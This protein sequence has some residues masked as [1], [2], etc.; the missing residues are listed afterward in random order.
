MALDPLLYLNHDDSSKDTN[1]T[2]V[3]NQSTK[4]IS[5]KNFVDSNVDP[6][7]GVDDVTHN[8]NGL[9]LPVSSLIDFLF[10]LSKILQNADSEDIIYFN[11]LNSTNLC[12]NFINNQFPSTIFI[13][14]LFI[15][16][17]TSK[18]TFLLLNT[19]IPLNQVLSTIVII[20]EKGLLYNRNF[21]DSQLQVINLPN[22]P[23]INS[24]NRLTTKFNDSSNIK[25]ITENS[26]IDDSNNTDSFIDNDNTDENPNSVNSSSNLII[27][28]DDRKSYETLRTL[29]N[30]GI[31]PYFEAL[32]QISNTPILDTDSQSL[33]ASISNNL[34]TKVSP[35]S[36]LI[37]INQL[38]TNNNNDDDNTGAIGSARKKLS[39]L[40]LSLQHIQ[41][42]V[43]IPDLSLTLH[44]TIKNAI[45]S[46]NH[47]NDKLPIDFIP[48]DLLSDSNFL[49]TLQSIANGWIK[50][51]QN[52]TKLSRD[53][54]EGSAADEINFWTSMES[55]LLNIQDQLNSPPIALTLEILTK[56]KRFYATL[57][58]TN[59]TGLKESLSTANKYNQLMKDLPLDELLSATTLKKIEEAIIL[60]MNHLKKLRVTNY[61]INRVLPFVEAISADLDSKLK[62]IIRTFNLMYLNF[63]EFLSKTQEINSVFLIWDKQ[64]KE[65]TNLARELLRKRSEKFIFIRINSKTRAL[66]ERL[67]YILTFRSRHNELIITLNNIINTTNKNFSNFKFNNNMN[68]INE[69]EFAFDAVRNID[70]ANTSAEGKKFWDSAEKIYNNRAQKVENAIVSMLR[71]ILSNSKSAN[72]MFSI[73]NKFNFLL[74]RP[75]VNDSIQEYQTQLLEIVKLDINN[76]QKHF[77]KQ[78]ESRRLFKAR[79]LPPV[80]SAIIWAKQIENKLNF[81]LNRLELILGKNWI[82]YVEGRK[83]Y[84][85]SVVFKKKLNTEPIYETWLNEVMENNINSCLELNIFKIVRNSNEKTDLSLVNGGLELVVNFDFN[86]IIIFK[87][88]RNLCWLNFQ[89]PHSIITS[90][91]LI[92]KVY[93]F[94]ISINESLSIFFESLIEYDTLN[95]ASILMKPIKNNLF[96]LLLDCFNIRWVDLSKAYDLQKLSSVLD[97]NRDSITGNDDLKTNITSSIDLI[98]NQYLK[99]VLSFQNSANTFH[100][101][102]ELL[103][104]FKFNLNVCFNE[105]LGCYYNKSSF[106]K[107]LS[108]IQKLVNEII[109][110]DY[111]NVSLLVKK[112]NKKIE[113]IFVSR[114]IKVTNIWIELLSN[115]Y[116]ENDFELS[117]TIKNFEIEE[118]IVSKIND[119]ETFEKKI[120][121]VKKFLPISRHEIILKDDTI[122][123]Y[124][125]IENSKLTWIWNLQQ[126]INIVCSQ[127]I[128]DESSYEIKVG[129]ENILN[130][131]ST[132]HSNELSLK[133]SNSRTNGHKSH[134]YG[135]F[136]KIN[137]SKAV[138]N[139]I[140]RCL[141]KIEE[142]FTK[143][144]EYVNSW[145]QF[146]SLYDLQLED[147]YKTLASDILSWLNVLNE[148]RQS[149]K[150]FDTIET[151]KKFGNY[152]VID[153]EQV[154]LR[155]NAKYDIWQKQIIFK[156][157]EILNLKM[158]QING[159]I[160]NAKNDLETK[161]NDL[162]STKNTVHLISNAY[163]YKSCYSLWQKN[164]S[165][166]SD[167]QA[168]LTRYRFRFPSD[169]L[170][171]EQMEG[172]FL[173]LT[174][175]L[176]MRMITIDSQIDAISKRIESESSRVNEIISSFKLNWSE[177]K[178][179]SGSIVPDDALRILKNFEKQ[180]IELQGRTDLLLKASAILSLSIAE[181][182]TLKNLF[183]EIQDL[184]NVWSS[185]DVLWKSLE[186]L[187][188][189]Q[190]HT[191]NPTKLN[192][193]LQQLLFRARTMPTRI[194]QYAAFED[195]QNV[196]KNYVQTNPLIT[197][198]KSEA[199]KHRHWLKLFS[200]L[201]IDSLSPTALRLGDIYSLQL[202]LHQHM[203]KEIVAQANGEKIIEDSLAKIKENWSSTTFNLFNYKNKC[204]L[205]K[206]WNILYEQ[207]GDDIASLVAMHHSTFF[208]IFEKEVINWE[209]KLNQLLSLFNVWIEVQRLWMYLEGIFGDNKL[210]IISLL[211]IESSRFNNIT[212]EFFLTMKRI[213]K[214]QMV[215]D[216][217]NNDNLQENM[218]RYFD[219]LSKVKKSLNDYLEKQR[220]LFP[221]FYFVGNEDL[222]E[223][224]G[225]SSDV[226]HVGKHLKKMFSGINS[227]LYEE[228]FIKGISSLEG[229]EVIL[230]NPVTKSSFL[231]EWLSELDIEIKVTL[232]ALLGSSLIDFTEIN[233]FEI[234]P[235][236]FFNWVKKY[237]AQVCLLT[238]QV[239]WTRI[240]ESSILAS[241]SN[242]EE[243]LKFLITKYERLLK[244]LAT[245]VIE[246]LDNI[247]IKKLEILIIELVHQRDVIIEMLKRKVSF[248]GDFYWKFQQTFYYDD[249]LEDY[250][251]RLKV[252][253]ANVVFS[254]GF[255]YL[256]IPDRLVYTPLTNQCFISMTQA[257]AQRL[258][259]SPF[260]PAGTGKTETI[261]SLGQNLGK[262]VLVFCCDEYFDFQAISRILFGVCRVGVWCCFDEFNRLQSSILSA[263]SSQIEKIETGLSSQKAIELSGKSAVVNL[264]TGIFITMNPTYAGRSSLPEN[265]KKQFRSFSMDKPDREIITEVI[266]IS[267]GFTTSKQISKI[268]A[269]FF[270]DL[271]KVAQKELHYDFG[272]RSIKSILSNCGKIKRKGFTL[273]EEKIAFKSIKSSIAPKLVSA[274]VEKFNE[275]TIKYFPKFVKDD[276]SDEYE[277]IIEALKLVTKEN[278]YSY[279]EEWIRKALQL[280]DI[281]SNHHGFILVGK[282]G[283]GKTVLWECL[284]KAL[285]KIDTIDNL[286]HVID[287]KVMSKE[288]LFGSLDSSTRDWTD[289]LFTSIL[290][291]IGENLRGELSKRVWIVLDGDIDPEWVENLNSV[292]DDNKILTL[293]NGER[294]NLPPNVKIVFEVDSL[295]YATPATV[296]RCGMIWFGNSLVS[297]TFLLSKFLLFLKSDL[298]EDM[299]DIA[300]AFQT[301]GLSLLDFQAKC[302]NYISDIFENSLLQECVDFSSSL[303]HI[304]PFDEIHLVNSF[305]SILKSY[306]RKLIVFVS[307]NLSFIHEDFSEYCRKACFLSLCFGFSGSSNLEGR[308]EF[309]KFLFE[310]C[311]LE[312]ECNIL[313][314][315]VSLPESHWI[316][317]LSKVPKVELQTHSITRPDVIVPTFDTVRHED[318]IYSIINEHSSLL[319]CGPPGSGKTMTL[320][321]ALRKSSNLESI[322]LN[323]SKETSPDL[324]IKTLEQYCE[325][326]RV[327][328]GLILAP[329]IPGKWLVIFCD[330]VNLPAND[331]Y[332]TQTV[333]SFIRQLIEKGGLYKNGSWVQTQNIQFVFACNPPTDAGRNPLSLRFLRHVCLITVGYPERISLNQIY[334]TFNNAIL[335]IIPQLRYAS[336]LLTSAMLSV[337]FECSK[338]FLPS[339]Q[340][341]YIY[342]PRELTR[343]VRGIY[344]AIKSLENLEFDDLVRLWAHEALRLFHD[345]LVSQSERTWVFELIKSVAIENFPNADIQKVF[346]EP[347]LYSNWLSLNYSSVDSDELRLFV[348]ERL[349]VFS[350]EEMDVH[351]VL[352]D[353]LLDH[354]LRI[355]RVLR[356]PQGHL[357]LVGPSGSGKTTLSR[358]VSWIN[359]LKIVQLNVSRKYSLRDFDNTL[360]DLLRRAGTLGEKICFIVDESN[361]KETAFLERM[362]T[363]L[364][365]S[366]IPGLFVGDELS[367][368]MTA[369]MDHSQSQGLL[370]DTQEE[371]YKWFTQQV[372]ENLHVIFTINNP[373]DKSSP[374]I[375]SSPALF[376]RCVLNWMGD[377]SNSTLYQVGSEMVQS[378]PIDM[379]DY[380]KPTDFYHIVPQ[381]VDTFRD[382]IIDAAVFIH[383]SE[384]KYVT[385]NRV[386]QK[387]PGHFLS[388][389]K[390]FIEI[391][392]RKEDELQEHQRH[393]NMGLDKLRNT[394]LEVKDLKEN[395]SEEQSKLKAKE[396]E[397][398][399]MLNKILTDQNQ[400][401][402]KQEAS[403]NIQIALEQQEIAIGERRTVVMNDLALAEP[404]VIEAQNGVKNIKKQHLT[405][406]RSMAN[407]PEAVKVT[408][409]SVCILL[410]YN[411]N[412]WRDVQL[413]IRR[414]DFIAS[415]VNYDNEEQLTPDIREFMEQE[416]LSRSTFNYATVN[417]ASKACGP[418]LQWVEAQ[419]RYSTILDKIAPLREEVFLLEDEAKQTK[420]KLIAINDMI[421][422]LK[423][424]I[425]ELKESY[426]NLITETQ[427]IKNKINSTHSKV[428]R[429]VSLLENLTIERRRWARSINDFTGQR[430]GLAGN[431]L[432]ASAFLSYCGYFDQ[433]ARNQLLV[434][435][436][437]KLES[438]G[439]TFDENIRIIEFLSQPN[440]ILQ[441][442][443]AGLPDDD[444]SV[445]NMILIQNQEKI[446]YI[447]DPTGNIVDIL[448]SQISPKKLITT[449][450]LDDGFVKQI[451]N[452]LRF[453]NS[454]LIQDA[455]HFDPIISRVISKEIQKAGGRSLIRL[456]KQEVDCSPDFKL[457]IQTKDPLVIVPPHISCRTTV[458]NF[459]VTE[460]SLESQTL[461]MT[462]KKERPDVE[463]QRIELIK[464][465]GEYKVR[466]R[467]LEDKLLQSL[468]D[469]EGNILDNDEIITT[470]ENLKVESKEIEMKIEETDNVMKTV[471]KVLENYNILSSNCS[472]IFSLLDRFQDINPFYQFSLTYFIDI[473]K[474]VL[475]LKSNKNENRVK[476]L[477][478]RLYQEIYS[479]TALSMHNSDRPVFGLCLYVLFQ[480]IQ[481]GKDLLQTLME[482]LGLIS[483]ENINPLKLKKIFEHFSI[484]SNSENFVTL[485]ENYTE[486]NF[487]LVLEENKDE[488]LEELKVLLEV[489]FKMQET[490]DAFVQSFSNLC[491]FLFLPGVPL[492]ASSYDFSNIVNIHNNSFE[493]FILCSPEGYDPTFK[494]KNLVNTFDIKLSTVAMGSA[495]AVDIANQEIKKASKEGY[496]VLIQNIQ[497]APLWL[498][499]LEKQLNSISAN[500]KFKLFLTCN[501][502]SDIPTTLLR[503]SFNLVFENPPGIKTV[504][505]EIFNEIPLERIERKPVERRHLYFLATWY[506]GIVQERLRY[507]PIGWSKRYDFNNADF[508][509]SLF[510]IDEWVDK[511]SKDRTNISPDIIPWKAIQHLISDVVYGGKVEDVEDRNY[512]SK[513]SAN[514]FSSGS[515]EIDFNLL[516]CNELDCQTKLFVPEG[517][518]VESYK[519]W[520][521]ELPDVEPPNWLGLEN[522]VESKINAKKGKEIAKTIQT[523]IGNIRKVQE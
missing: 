325:Y 77:L 196:I 51:V 103:K 455:E 213:F 210:D 97:Q 111:S 198:L 309:S 275:L 132:K 197:E 446:P 292:L 199:I 153:Y 142:K 115:E 474:T 417:R 164:L 165:L 385:Q 260:G 113:T 6:N 464:L 236:S 303:F 233:N 65:F 202:L 272:L 122:S 18:N 22:Y 269:G 415:I 246:K 61:P 507:V 451:E 442:R 308:N 234:E 34:N 298:L 75:S 513:L 249:S 278:N 484:N 143:G 422:E 514:V 424:N 266:L 437:S 29:I 316:P 35:G 499:Y 50:S 43:Q 80:S 305:L 106:E 362:N 406:I 160:S 501:L 284:L 161:N 25:S 242:S 457:Y 430:K 267:Q 155:V 425:E 24:V 224:I 482:I 283:F 419:V 517:R 78:T 83:I 256:G 481:I 373:N 368:L 235:E 414:D 174:Q 500:S 247:T 101:K 223:I 42:S 186:D 2:L 359:G 490:P 3:M 30:L 392:L 273:D 141:F 226:L 121:D 200:E 390:N 509:S 466:L 63:D 354:I 71:E 238:A 270:V 145:V 253:Q 172:D 307:N 279:N 216:V 230:L 26:D 49:N 190:F 317:W 265:L 84:M 483:E 159:E 467:F 240:V 393:I 320:F 326:K 375:I 489:L 476:S 219:A 480:S 263:V 17:S 168:F 519:R 231:N 192:S 387:T 349:R 114:C 7:Q 274:D 460:S 505:N 291:K 177:K 67:E 215:I 126:A 404:A 318:L 79:D 127:R 394:V 193:L 345:R 503:T 57:S 107:I 386:P 268:I 166:F 282:S 158:K 395:L 324:L 59:D 245:S 287:C 281:Q 351:L 477:I 10:N 96:R 363:L 421:Q 69:M 60:I 184:M 492:F 250:V 312:I 389:I 178:P 204:R 396:A 12:K 299:E 181:D 497:M 259:G 382:V 358:F 512:L 264:N 271:Q 191:I 131:M 255:E 140:E 170:Y 361:I 440:E 434:I 371:L 227:L 20:K 176:N 445:E 94:A 290:R 403:E 328:N 486:D 346:L 183:E 55:A 381:Y 220:E 91:R 15:K 118:N 44:H 207:S 352:Y 366:E 171:F 453:G 4:L 356:Q 398:K 82:E 436:K 472:A 496:W 1:D 397:A 135:T 337:Y 188:S 277:K 452:A 475:S 56:A 300:T 72:E 212:S 304:M 201:N 41:Q 461:N 338:H 409:E 520:I 379:P 90:A 329:S 426:Q 402:R 134:I 258:G 518:T 149:R 232:S 129:N 214:S 150:T 313:D 510:V 506:Y 146:Q 400:A 21:L 206:D 433:K 294:I 439:I 372:T 31:S 444:L 225:N 239:F 522:E 498:E 169:W 391:F 449:S 330:E 147:V 58:L 167:G 487:K 347:I 340:V 38:S 137:G 465:H 491:N 62:M 252:H 151:E 211:P 336:T 85:E 376:N 243:N 432:L 189:L 341:H 473:F 479:R 348:S 244:L 447:I 334:E 516:E 53:P 427:I 470:L 369:C 408:M 411:V 133:Y 280:Y 485:L 350:E 248:I 407:P 254:Y 342:S 154:Q 285:N 112:I 128:I 374:Q 364:A 456:G 339:S 87:E 32:T 478:L 333:I 331:K 45:E 327:A 441:W 138:L 515:F 229:E 493:P 16:N 370:L 187:R 98:E 323:F 353:E 222:L 102:I 468:S 40:I 420:A 89:V 458:V 36:N 228:P 173:A 429:C 310:K 344:E 28:N 523:T 37:S 454:I 435:W 117:D 76:L 383:R 162:S 443:K 139:Q 521:N 88:V 355:D 99:N 357:I 494:V 511:V 388:L 180:A 179:I 108:M 321:T 130:S 86:L 378:V 322:S 288:D 438:S 92:R 217:L 110:E 488:K 295:K 73:F 504:M 221:R 377:W 416:Y 116:L 209:E 148:I 276:Q 297:S 431:S 410:G 5:K 365:N 19:L 508:Q 241:K 156:F 343:W 502:T 469:T 66:K 185:I 109:L 93:P 314:Y 152:L 463:K 95:E 124:P 175:T 136:H 70:I 251:E 203:V 237:P 262:M 296:S 405:E 459:T 104:K 8:E 450:F 286:Y 495:E 68:P 157:S 9:V 335:K 74:S 360:R 301:S 306:I 399:Q 319:L 47:S 13:V 27:K 119:Q 11:N 33:I 144:K 471:E 302:S 163:K 46:A 100:N 64:I 332:G 428:N 261:K 205:V 311:D 182:K 195:I 54:S 218:Q 413:I 380:T 257:A 52:V 462:L 293:P 23:L 125:P 401:E 48:E 448:I 123:V 14:K 208:K 412:T 315:D 81:L 120:S 105:L 418:L 423:D 289:G 194:R 384:I 39:E 367:S